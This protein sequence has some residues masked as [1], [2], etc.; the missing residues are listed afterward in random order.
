MRIDLHVHTYYSDDS[1]MKPAEVIRTVQRLGLDGV[2]ITDHNTIT[3]ARELQA[4]A[5]FLVIVGEEIK[6]TQGE[7]IGLFL[8]EPIPRGLSPE[9]TIA[10]IRQQEAVVYVPHP[11]DR[12]RTSAMGRRALLRII[13]QVDALEVF[14]ARILFPRENAQARELALRYG[15]A[16]G[17]GSDA[18]IASEIGRGYVIMEPFDGPASFLASLT[19]GEAVGVLTSPLIHVVTSLTKAYRTYLRRG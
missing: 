13:H 14:N 11:L 8:R 18:H 5:P 6:T 2:A 12:I 7:I 16:M 4:V 15:L 17:A 19:R 3:G 10:A 9:E 1:L